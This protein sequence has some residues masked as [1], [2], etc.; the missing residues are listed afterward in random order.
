M[1]KCI[2]PITVNRCALVMHIEYNEAI[3]LS[4]YIIMRFKCTHML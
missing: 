4:D 2:T 1:E 3:F